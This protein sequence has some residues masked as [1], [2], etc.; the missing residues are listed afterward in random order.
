[1]IEIE[2]DSETE[3]NVKI[4][5]KYESH[6]AF[7][8]EIP[9]SFGDKLEGKFSVDFLETVSAE[10]SS[11]GVGSEDIPPENSSGEENGFVSGN[12]GTNA[13]TV[14]SEAETNG[15]K[16][17][18]RIKPDGKLPVKMDLPNGTTF[19][20]IGLFEN[21]EISDLPEGTKISTDEG[22]S[23]YMI[24]GGGI[25]EFG[26]SGFF[27]TESGYS[28]L[29]D[30]EKAELGEREE[31][32]VAVEAFSSLGKLGDYN[33]SVKTDV[34]GT[35]NI[36]KVSA[37]H[38]MEIEESGD[39]QNEGSVLL[40]KGDWIKTEFPKEWA[41]ESALMCSVQ[42]L[43]I[44]GDGKPVYVSADESFE[45]SYTVD[46]FCVLTIKPGEMLPAAG[47]YQAYIKWEFEG[48]CFYKDRVTFFINY[49]SDTYS[50]FES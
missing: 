32:T 23:Y 44:S 13:Q 26:L 34:D 4:V 8:V 6:Q 50:T 7:T 46:D 9:V 33:I 24:F 14:D 18:S 17:V 40:S 10:D 28:L 19:V 3:I 36:K 2:K 49:L 20:R 47:T 27:I 48:I 30:F 12:S 31:I 16:S 21:G 22:G 5:S 42:I 37:V 38:N 29:L 25:A 39:V 43:S 1:E 41:E 35:G 45:P 15:L 11:N